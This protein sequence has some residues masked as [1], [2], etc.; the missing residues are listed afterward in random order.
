MMGGVRKTGIKIVTFILF[1]LLI[2]SFA[3]WGVGDIVRG[4]VSASAILQVDDTPVSQE[5]FTRSLQQARTRLAQVIGQPIGM[6]EAR[7]FGLV[8]QVLSDLTGRA[9]L[10]Q[11]AADM[12]LEV[13]EDQLRDRIRNEQAFHNASGQFDRLIFDQTLRSMGL[14][15][16][17]LLA[18]LRR[19][20]MQDHIAEVVMDGI[21]APDTLAESLYRFRSE[22]RIAE[23]MVLPRSGIEAPG[24]P[25]EAALKAFHEENANLFM[26]PE[27]RTL[28]YI[29]VRVQDLAE[30]VIIS[31]ETL[32]EA[33][34]E[35]RE[36]YA[37]PERRQ[38]QQFVLPD[39]AAATAAAEQ[40][41]GGADF[42]AVAEETTGIAPID[43]GS[44]TR[45]ELLPEIADGVFELAAGSPSAPLESP[46]GWHLV[47][48]SDIQ[49][50]E[51]PDF[52]KVRDELKT[53]LADTEAFDAAL[54]ISTEIDDALSGGV[55]LE[56]AAAGQGQSV[57][58]IPA[59]QRNGQ[60]AEGAAIPDLPDQSIFLREAFSLDEGEESLIVETQAGDYFA[61]RV[62]AI[63]AAVLRPFD[64][65]R[66]EVL[67]AWREGEVS[68]LLREKAEALAARLSEAGDL[69]GLGTAEGVSLAKTEPLRRDDTG[70]DKVPTPA[71][72]AALFDAKLNEPVT[73]EA[74]DGYIVGK[75]IEILEADPSGDAEG[76]TALREQLSAG[77]SQDFLAQFSAALRERYSVTVNRQLVDRLTGNY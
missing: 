51:E 38:V 6:E 76:V 21:G 45:D 1:G 30:Q 73:A 37:V 50:R 18:Q 40:L 75:L 68:R 39:E 49:P 72:T 14:S 56:E 70:S 60:D 17:M 46:L 67:E 7:S 31:D 5:D 27:T 16:G 69:A 4:P 44:L 65:V 53:E 36:T 66:D 28:S 41:T 42:A 12:G 57:K 29:H 26:S 3:V 13:T 2:L 77:M 11:L 47:L 25:E 61:V 32:K 8:D 23:Y 9:M 71:L 35:R 74:P 19:E 22:R 20:T 24:D 54:V 10:E 52:D 58:E 48:V 62:D 64:E 43:L 59:I 33:F 34:E 63:N 15:E 55:S